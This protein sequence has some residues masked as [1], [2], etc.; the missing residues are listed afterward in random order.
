MPPSALRALAG[1]IDRSFTRI[2]AAAVDARTFD[3]ALITREAALSDDIDAVFAAL[4]AR[5]AP[6]RE[7]AAPGREWAARRTLRWIA[8]RDGPSHARVA[9]HP[10]AEGIPLPAPPPDDPALPHRIASG[11]VGPPRRRPLGEATRGALSPYDPADCRF[12]GLEAEFCGDRRDAVL[13]VQLPRRYDIDEPACAQAWLRIRCEAVT[14][15]AFT[16]GRSPCGALSWHAGEG[17]VEVLAGR[18]GRLVAERATLEIEDTYWYL[19]EPGRAAAAVLPRHPGRHRERWPLASALPEHRGAGLAGALVRQA[20]A[21]TA[22]ARRADRVDQGEILDLCRVFEG[23][24]TDAL[25]AG[26]RGG[27]AFRRLILRWVERGGDPLAGWFAGVLHVNSRPG[28]TGAWARALAVELTRRPAPARS[29]PPEVPPDLPAAAVLRLLSVDFDGHVHGGSR[30]GA[31]AQ[32]AVPPAD[33]GGRREGWDLLSVGIER[34]EQVRLLPGAFTAPDRL[35]PLRQ[36]ARSLES[37]SALSVSWNAAG[38]IRTVGPQP[39][40]SIVPLPERRPRRW[41]VG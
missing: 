14:E 16:A 39:I 26:A 21:A 28:P 40:I 22:K 24:G 15:L 10:E 5:P 8:G 13:T 27:R 37:G 20:L 12:L 4:S 9:A 34:L 7:W 38:R 1:L 29:L 32:F 23:A 31:V 18:H 33:G 3:R 11:W 41:T 2:A 36:G 35:Q 25:A 19:S 17:G 6:G 30:A